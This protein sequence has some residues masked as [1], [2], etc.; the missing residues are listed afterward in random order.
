MTPDETYKGPERRAEPV[1]KLVET[2]AEIAAAKALESDRKTL[3]WVATLRGAAI[4]LAI[5]APSAY[6][7]DQSRS[8]AALEWARFNCSQRVEQANILKD[9]IRSNAKRRADQVRPLKEHPKIVEVYGDLF[10]D[11]LI[12]ELLAEQ[13][14]YDARQNQY[15]TKL[16]IPRVD[17]LTEVVCKTTLTPG[18]VEVQTTTVKSPTT[19]TITLP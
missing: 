14:G 6:F 3:V 10:G 12:G 16:L 9:L 19:P 5:I 4:A 7:L 2:A 8:S 17:K 1:E 11:N 18:G 13:A 15:F